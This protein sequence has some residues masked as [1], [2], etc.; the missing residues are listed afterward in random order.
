MSIWSNM[1]Y[2]KY[3]T[4]KSELDKINQA[5]IEEVNSYIGEIE[6]P[7]LFMLQV[8]L[9]SENLL[10]RYIVA[11]LPKGKK[12]IENGR[13]SYYQKVQV[14]GAFGVVDDGVLSSL[15]EF[16][17]V[18]NNLAHNLNHEF[19][20]KHLRKFS[21]PLGGVSSEF[22]DRANG[23]LIKELKLTLNH[24]V[25]RLAGFTVISEKLTRKYS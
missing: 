8:H 15:T 7:I 23:C 4:K 12:L 5:A 9:Y 13:L 25:C 21:L 17:K 14:V 6:N 24:L 22:T 18:R 10:E 16:N 20:H 11:E 3:E 19:T 1:E 2:S